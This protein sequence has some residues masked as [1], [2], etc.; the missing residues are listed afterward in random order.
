MTA[1]IAPVDVRPR[2]RVVAALG[3][4][5]RAAW[6]GP[7]DIGLRLVG[8]RY[9]WLKA[10]LTLTPPRLLE[11]LGRLRAERAVWR[12]I[13]VV[14]AYRAYVADAGA[15]AD[16]VRPR[17]IP[18]HAA[19]DRQEQLCRI[20]YRL[21]ERCTNGRFPFAGTTLDESSGSTGRPYDWIRSERERTVAH[22]NIAFSLATSSAPRRSSPSTRSRWVRG[23]QGST[24]PRA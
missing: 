6:L 8:L 4:R 7:L 17:R 9:A 11:L 10:L 23:R 13:E 15:P 21:E 1:G 16:K 24:P 2:S 14:P 19:G 3:G 5:L 18:G 22:R 12:A 20:D